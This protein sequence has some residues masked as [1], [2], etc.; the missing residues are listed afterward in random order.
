MADSARQPVWL[1]VYF[2]G[3]AHILFLM[4]VIF[5]D[6]NFQVADIPEEK[7]AEICQF[8]QKLQEETNRNLVLVAYESVGK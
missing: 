4:E 1:R 2:W 8:Q 7:I 5:L 6:H 3:L